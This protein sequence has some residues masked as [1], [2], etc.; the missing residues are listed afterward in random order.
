MK[1][2]EFYDEIIKRVDQLLNTMSTF[3]P[4][5]DKEGSLKLQQLETEEIRI[6]FERKK[7]SDDIEAYTKSTQK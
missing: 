6:A 1:Q 4:N 3:P 5:S 7:L 2:E